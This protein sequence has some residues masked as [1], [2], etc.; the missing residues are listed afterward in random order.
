MVGRRAA[1]SL[2]PGGSFGRELG[3][4]TTLAIRTSWPMSFPSMSSEHGQGHLKMRGATQT[5]G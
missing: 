4:A 1:A 2:D 5:G 3:R